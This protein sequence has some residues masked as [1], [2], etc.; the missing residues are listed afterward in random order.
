MA[1]LEEKVA[2]IT[3]GTSGIGAATA[4]VFA[5]N[6]A[7]VILSGRNIENGLMIEKE[8]INKGGIAKFISCDVAD[9]VQAKKLIE[10]TGSTFEHTDI[11]FNNA[12]VML[13]SMEVERMP[14]EDWKKTFSMNYVVQPIEAA[15]AVLFLASDQAAYL[16]GVI[17][18]IDGGVSL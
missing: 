11:L 2:I 13:P 6:G 12:G 3:G 1:Q 5:E 18:P 7:A 8:I 14:I 9:S 17:L 10:E 4:K 16:T 15:K